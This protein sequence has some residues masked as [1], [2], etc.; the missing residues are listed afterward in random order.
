MS[1][2]VFSCPSGY[3]ALVRIK[4]GVPAWRYRYHGVYE[5]TRISTQPNIGAYHSSEIPIV[6]GATE[7]RP[8][9]DKDTLEEAKLSLNIRHAWAEFAKNPETGLVKLGWPVYDPASESCL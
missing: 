5:N 4:A 8:G 1:D 6:F 9:V 7:L 2:A 3:A